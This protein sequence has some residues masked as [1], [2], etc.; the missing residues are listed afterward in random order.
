MLPPLSLVTFGAMVYRIQHVQEPAT[1]SE[2]K[3]FTMFIV[4]FFSFETV[5]M[6][7]G[8]I[9]ISNISQEDLDLPTLL[10]LPLLELQMSITIPGLRSGGLCMEPGFCEG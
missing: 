1:G 9:S 7:P 5:L 8:L 6:Q 3:C 4:S 2:V 10:S